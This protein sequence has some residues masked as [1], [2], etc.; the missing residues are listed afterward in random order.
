MSPERERERE[1]ESESLVLK[2]RSGS[3]KANGREPKTGL[4]RN[5][6]S[7]LGYIATPGRVSAWFA[8]SH[9]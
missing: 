6:N 8:C 9:F 4:G 7:K 1:R 2:D 5:F 3:A